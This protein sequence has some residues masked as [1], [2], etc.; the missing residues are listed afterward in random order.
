MQTLPLFPLQVVLFPGS[1]MPLHIFE[2][3]YRQ[4]LADCLASDRS[5]GILPP[6]PGESG[7]TPAIGAVG[8][9]AVITRHDPLPDGRSN[10]VV[11]GAAR[12][13]LTALV[14]ND[15]RYLRGRTE[16][17]RDIGAV[18]D[19]EI[20]SRLR[21]EITEWLRSGQPDQQPPRIDWSEDP[22]TFSFQAAA[23]LNLDHPTRQRLLEYRSSAERV[24][25]LTLLLPELK[26]VQQQSDLER[27]AATN[28]RATD[29]NGRPD[30]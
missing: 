17:Y 5:F 28:G 24:M 7:G 30:G 12:F 27:I 9:Q 4:M 25:E 15:R 29:N 18:A 6:P 3:R 13:R 2:P 14:E 8:C 22:T 21:Q 19:P 26:R 16:E 11:S 20:I 10:I 1:L 23:V